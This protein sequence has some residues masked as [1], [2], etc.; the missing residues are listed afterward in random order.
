MGFLRGTPLL[1]FSQLVAD[2]ASSLQTSKLLT[3]QS[4]GYAA[5]IKRWVEIFEKQ[6][7]CTISLT[8]SI[9]S[10]LTP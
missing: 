9:K 10:V 2:L 7:V 3:P 5:K 6:A 8:N 4:E 1:I